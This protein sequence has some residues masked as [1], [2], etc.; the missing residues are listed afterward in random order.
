MDFWDSLTKTLGS[1]ADRTARETEKLTSLA[2]L[3][4]KKASLC[5]Q[6]ELTEQRLGRVCYEASRAGTALPSDQTE[7]LMA[8]ID[9]LDGEIT[10]LEDAIARLQTH[11]L[12]PGCGGRVTKEMTFCPA[13]GTKLDAEP[14]TETP[15]ATLS[16]PVAENDDSS[17]EAG[18]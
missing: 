10:V 18:K 1:A 2:K 6:R 5:N 7:P 17:E 13:C 3:K 14:A 12:C 4:Y 16:E 15:A 8:E 9:R 11:R